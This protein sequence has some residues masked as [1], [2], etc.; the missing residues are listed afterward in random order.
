MKKLILFTMATAFSALSIA[1]T[2]SF[3]PLPNSPQGKAQA[4]A[5]AKKQAQS[6][7]PAQAPVTPPP[8]PVAPPPASA[9]KPVTPTKVQSTKA[10]N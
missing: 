7:P 4:E 6:S 10:P 5:L 8:K 3:N 9:Q 1:G 2:G